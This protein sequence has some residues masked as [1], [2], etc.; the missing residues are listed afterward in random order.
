MLLLSDITNPWIQATVSNNTIQLGGTEAS[1]A[2]AGVESLYSLGAVISNNRISGENAIMGMAVE[3]DSQCMIKGNNLQQLQP[4]W[5]PVALLGVNSG[6]PF[7][8]SDCTVVGGNN[9]TN[10]YDE[11]T[12]DIVVGVNNMNGNPPGPAIRDAMKRKMEMIKSIRNP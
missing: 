8:T 6:F 1:P 4:L 11:G 3:A 9:K 12:N 2:Y 7:D 10:V 5:V